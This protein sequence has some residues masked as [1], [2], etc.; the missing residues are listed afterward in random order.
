MKNL[1]NKNS[2]YNMNVKSFNIFDIFCAMGYKLGYEDGFFRNDPL[3]RDITGE[4]EIQF[5]PEICHITED[6]RSMSGFLSKYGVDNSIIPT[7]ISVH[8]VNDVIEL[9][10]A[11]ESRESELLEKERQ[12]D[13]D[14]N[15]YYER[16]RRM[17][18]F[19]ASEEEK[20]L[21]T[22]IAEARERVINGYRPPKS[23][24]A[25]KESLKVLQHESE[26]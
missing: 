18:E 26:L 24:F 22:S 2:K 15:T 14:M 7:P 8:K 21:K 6:I 3:Y 1:Q 20:D 10:P 4:N 11:M 12:E 19:I 16:I 5:S 13:N 23:Y 9:K 25:L 17:R